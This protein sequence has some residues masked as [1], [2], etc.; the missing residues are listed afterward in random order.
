MTNGGLGSARKLRGIYEG[1]EW[2]ASLSGANISVED[3]DH[4]FPW[5]QENISVQPLKN[6]FE[7]LDVAHRLIQIS[8]PNQMVGWVYFRIEPDDENCTLLWIEA[9]WFQRVG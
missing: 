1:A 4:R 7:F 3:W 9:R 8:F 2:A 6:T 5:A